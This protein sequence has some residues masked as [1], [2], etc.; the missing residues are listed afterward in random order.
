LRRA[1]LYLYYHPEEIP[2]LAQERG[3]KRDVVAKVPDEPKPPPGE[4]LVPETER[5]KRR[6]AVK[7]WAGF[8]LSGSGR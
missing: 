4:K 5:P 2:A 8:L 7:Q 3:P 1:Q 6:A